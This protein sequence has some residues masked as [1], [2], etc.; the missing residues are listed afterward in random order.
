[1]KEFKIQK[2]GEFSSD[3]FNEEI[4]LALERIKSENYLPGFTQELIKNDIESAMYL[5]GELRYG[6]YIIFQ[7]ENYTEPMGRL[8]CFLSADKSFISIMAV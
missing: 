7:I 6:N 1:M 8:H 4:K 3:I 2:T 5:G